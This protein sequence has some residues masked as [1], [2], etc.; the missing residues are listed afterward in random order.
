MEEQL[1]YAMISFSASHIDYIC[2]TVISARCKTVRCSKTA[3]FSLLPVGTNCNLVGFPWP[4][5]GCVHC[6]FIKASLKAL[7]G[8]FHWL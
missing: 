7:Y 6:C 3:I 8:I 2:K 1:Y 5:K 4:D